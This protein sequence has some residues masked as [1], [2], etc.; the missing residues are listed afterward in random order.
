MSVVTVGG[1]GATLL[2]KAK[3]LT[4]RAVCGDGRYD[5]LAALAKIRGRDLSEG[6][7]EDQRLKIK[8]KGGVCATNRLNGLEKMYVKGVN[9]TP[10]ELRAEELRIRNG[11]TE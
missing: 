4:S 2:E 8:Q 5:D 6:D 11:G 10:Q 7:W 1:F 9:P 3:K